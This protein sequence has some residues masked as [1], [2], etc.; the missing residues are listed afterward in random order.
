MTEQEKIWFIKLSAD[1]ANDAR[2]FA[3]PEYRGIWNSVIDK[4]SDNAHFVYELLQNA[5]DAGATE[6]SFTLFYGVGIYFEHNGTRHF[7][8]SNPDTSEEDQRNGR[9]GCVNAISAIGQ[10]AK[11]VEEG[12]GNQIGKFGIGF[13]SVFRYTDTPKIYDDNIQFELRDRIVPCLIDD[14]PNLRKRIAMWPPCRILA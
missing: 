1:H 11:I 14:L 6:A 12:V 10:S 7:T 5:D 8:I 3:K 9:L 2:T 4:Y 13:K